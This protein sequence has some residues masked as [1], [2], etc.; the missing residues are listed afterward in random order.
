M[1]TTSLFLI[2][3][4][5]FFSCKS[6]EEVQKE[7]THT[8]SVTTSVK[9]EAKNSSEVKIS[10]Q[11]EEY[12]GI[13]TEEDLTSGIL[14]VWFMPG[15]EAYD[16]DQ[17]TVDKIDKNIDDYSIKVFM[18]TWCSDS[19]REIPKFFKLLDRIDYNQNNL[20]VITTDLYKTTKQGY[21]KEYNIDF[22]PTI[23]FI[24]KNGEEV[25][26]FVEF[27][28]ESLEEDILK[29]VTNQPYT[30]SYAD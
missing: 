28:Q 19:R 12:T 13:I 23:I 21:E 8:T 2:V 15:Y 11:E 16:P 22:V 25:N 29:I 6:N 7:T 3:A 9:T 10:P 5:A 4:L 27:P 26:R 30:N 24:D 14:K 1:K 18:G 20:E 17:E